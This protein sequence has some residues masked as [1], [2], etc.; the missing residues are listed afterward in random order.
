MGRSDGRRGIVRLNAE[1]LII[2]PSAGACMTPSSTN[3][4]ASK[5]PLSSFRARSDAFGRLPTICDHDDERTEPVSSK[6]PG[7]T[8]EG[9]PP[10]QS[11]AKRK[12]ERSIEVT[13]YVTKTEKER[14]RVRAQREGIS[15]SEIVRAAIRAFFQLGARP[16]EPPA[17]APP[18]MSDLFAALELPATSISVPNVVRRHRR[19]RARRRRCD[20]CCC[21][22]RRVQANKHRVQS[23][24]SRLARDTPGEQAVPHDEK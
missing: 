12:R 18:P 24:S 21:R 13:A 4:A 17:I 9:E 5:W 15:E 10:E 14:V 23:D 16:A 11:R 19:R 1:S 2:V 7:V 20:C 6:K 3:S 8:R 22:Y